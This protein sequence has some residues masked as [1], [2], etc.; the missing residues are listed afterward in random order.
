M[1]LNTLKPKGAAPKGVPHLVWVALKLLLIVDLGTAHRFTLSSVPLP[2]SVVVFP[3][4]EITLVLVPTILPS[5][6]NV[7]EYLWEVM[8]LMAIWSAP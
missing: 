1:G 5:F 7:A 6:F 2:L 3:S 8:R 4:G